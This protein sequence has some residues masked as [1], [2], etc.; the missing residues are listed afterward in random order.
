MSGVIRVRIPMDIRAVADSGSAAFALVTPMRVRDLLTLAVRES[1]GSRAPADKFARSMRRTLNGF[2][3]GDFT[4]Q[5]DGRRFAD[6][7]TVVVCDGI[8][9]VRFFLNRVTLE[10]ES[11]TRS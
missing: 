1:I 7:E 6:P 9:D 3:S 2:L 8:V 11:R 4:V 10:T 5:I